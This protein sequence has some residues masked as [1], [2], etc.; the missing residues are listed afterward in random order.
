MTDEGKWVVLDKREYVTKYGWDDGC[1]VGEPPRP[2]Y[3]MV[4][5]V[6]Y[7]GC[8][9]LCKF[10]NGNELEDHDDADSMHICDSQEFA[11]AM[12]ALPT[13]EQ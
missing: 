12:L 4:A 1:T 2:W 5:Y 6:K 8:V 9:S 10:Y 7:D 13:P 11:K 3:T